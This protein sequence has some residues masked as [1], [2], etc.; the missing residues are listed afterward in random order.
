VDGETSSTV[1]ANAFSRPKRM[2]DQFQASLAEHL[3]LGL[4]GVRDDLSSGGG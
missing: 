1:D 4:G 2:F 3:D